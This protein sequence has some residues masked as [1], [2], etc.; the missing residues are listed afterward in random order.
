MCPIRA[1]ISTHKKLGKCIYSLFV[2]LAVIGFRQN[3]IY[4]LPNLGDLGAKMSFFSLYNQP[5][6]K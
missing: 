5:K 4:I 3:Y 6:T 1:E 2:W